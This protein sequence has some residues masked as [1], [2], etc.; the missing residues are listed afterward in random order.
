MPLPLFALAVA[1]FGIGT[2]EFVIMGLLP[3]VARDLGATIPAAGMLVSGYALSVTIGAPIVALLTAKLP[4]KTTLLGLMGV[5]ILGN[6]MCALAPDYWSLMAARVLTALC[7]GAFFGI[8]AVVATGLVPRHQRS[9]AV[10]LMFSGLTLA[11]VL[12]VPFGTALG[13]VAGWRATFGAIVPI[14]IA[15]ALAI[16]F[17][18]PRD[19]EAPAG[20]LLSEFSVLRKP[21][22]LLAMALSILS[23]VSLFTVFTYIT[24][25]LETVSGLTPQ[26]VTTAL[27]LFGVGITVGNLFGG[28][29]ADWRLMPAVM[30]SF[31]ALA[32]VC[33][34][35]GLAAPFMVPAVAAMVLWGVVQF[36]LGAPLQT[37]VVDQAHEA[38]NLAST[39]NQGA[40]NLGNAAGAWLGGAAITAGMPY[41]QIPYLGAAV[42][43][44]GLAVAVLSYALDRRAPALA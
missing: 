10:A 32:V 17:I 41:G 40:F 31:T 11:N 3:D 8:G 19:R 13:H 42:A 4:R 2:T 44:A 43:V 21:Q 24:P 5:F 9:R 18:L 22:V 34:G 20:N 23:S 29:L 39:L 25:I 28:R 6:L 15:A 36:S 30:I 16:A 38:P 12:G 35:F 37:R 14:G 27:L 26:G 1:A 7:H 33:A